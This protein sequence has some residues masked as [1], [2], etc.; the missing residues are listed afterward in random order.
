MRVS[1]DLDFEKRILVPRPPKVTK[2]T[3]DENKN[4]DLE[5]LIQSA[6][7]NTAKTWI[8]APITPLDFFSYPKFTIPEFEKKFAMM[9]KEPRALV[10]TIEPE[11]LDFN[12]IRSYNELIFYFKN[13]KS[14]TPIPEVLAIKIVHPEVN[15]ES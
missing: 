11:R 6:N 13:T 8:R 14:L 3:P 2:S 12:I 10:Y 7:P 15:Y 5:Y 9:V 4:Y 1:Q